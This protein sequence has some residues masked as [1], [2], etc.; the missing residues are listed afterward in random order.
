MAGG[1]LVLILSLVAIL[2]P[3]FHGSE[4][5]GVMFLLGHNFDVRWELGVPLVL[6]GVIL[7]F[8]DQRRRRRI[9]WYHRKATNFK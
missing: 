6:T 4:K 7:L 3:V 5:P 9:S 1:L 8:V 2:F